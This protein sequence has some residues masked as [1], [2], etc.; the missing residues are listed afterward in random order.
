VTGYSSVDTFNS[1]IEEVTLSLGGFGS[2]NDMVCSLAY[3]IAANDLIIG[4]DDSAAV[5][6][7]IIEIDDELI[8]VT[9][10]NA[11]EP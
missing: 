4:V 1:L 8:F 9:S 2:S 7:G 3:D 6:K 11:R 5:S 10:N